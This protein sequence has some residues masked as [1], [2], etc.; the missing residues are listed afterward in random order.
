MQLYRDLAE[1]LWGA[2]KALVQMGSRRSFSAINTRVPR[3]SYPRLL[4]RGNLDCDSALS[5]T[6]EESVAL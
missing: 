6:S 2:E 5:S 4:A 1:L 3:T